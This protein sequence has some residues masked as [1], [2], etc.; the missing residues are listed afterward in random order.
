MTAELFKADVKSNSKQNLR[1]VQQ[2]LAQQANTIKL[3]KRPDNQI[4]K[5]CKSKTMQKLEMDQFTTSDE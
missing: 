5:K 3:E 1:T 4:T 2:R